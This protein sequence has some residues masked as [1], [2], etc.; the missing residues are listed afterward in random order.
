M[1]ARWSA[2]AL[3]V[4]CLLL[5]ARNVPLFA[6]SA[7]SAQED[8]FDRDHERSDDP[9][10]DPSEREESGADRMLPDDPTPDDDE[11]QQDEGIEEGLGTQE[12]ANAFRAELAPR[13]QRTRPLPL[14]RT[15]YGESN[16]HG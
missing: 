8:D 7:A 15:S 2:V 16:L 6:P 3:F 14:A 12:S 9:R 4:S 13:G 1:H 5:D 11:P 10:N